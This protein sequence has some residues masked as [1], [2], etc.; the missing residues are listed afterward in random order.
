[1]LR[2]TILLVGKTKSSE[3]QALLDDYAKRMSRSLDLRVIVCKTEEQ[4]WDKVDSSAYLIALEADGKHLTSPEFAATLH[5]LGVQGQ[6]HIQFIIGP[7]EGFTGYKK[8]PQLRL[9]L[10][11]MTFSHQTIR[12]HLFEQLYRACTVWE[13]KPFAK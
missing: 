10:S 3:L 7:A 13:G 8:Q 9:S 4:L 5:R 6:S 11:A 12:L 2:I 1:M